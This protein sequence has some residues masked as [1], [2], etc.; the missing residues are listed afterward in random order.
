MPVSNHA[1]SFH[2]SESRA[3]QAFNCLDIT[4]LETVHATRTQIK[5]HGRL[6]PYKQ[7]NRSRLHTHTHTHTH[8]T[9]TTRARDLQTNEPRHDRR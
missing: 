7:I 3:N 9:T 2:Y 1:F 8:T 6:A 4:V 5:H